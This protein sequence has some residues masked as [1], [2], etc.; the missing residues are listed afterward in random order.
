MKGLLAGFP[1]EQVQA[2]L[3]YLQANEKLVKKFSYE[4]RDFRFLERLRFEAFK[5]SSEFTEILRR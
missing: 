1:Y 2:I 4:L 5:N 3:N